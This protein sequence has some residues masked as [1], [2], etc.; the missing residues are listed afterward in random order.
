M[1]D[2]VLSSSKLRNIGVDFKLTKDDIFDLLAEEAQ[3]LLDKASKDAR[4]RQEE[5]RAACEVVRAALKAEQN[6]VAKKLCQ[7][8]FTAL[9]RMFKGFVEMETL[10]PHSMR[11]VVREKEH[12][13]ERA[14]IACQEGT[15]H[16]VAT[17]D[18][19]QGMFDYNAYFIRKDGVQRFYRVLLEGTLKRENIRDDVM[20]SPHVQHATDLLSDALGA[21]NAAEKA[22]NEA[23]R[24]SC[25]F[26]TSKKKLR[27]S[28]LRKLLSADP[29]SADVLSNI[30][31]LAHKFVLAVQA[32]DSTDSE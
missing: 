26:H 19:A 22:A 31:G 17:Y 12:Y 15:G 21:Y 29:Q 18:Y 8:Q 14:V 9:A 27:V 5:A 30:Q 10:D 13:M 24:A 28:L 1:T 3:S 4:S 25:N 6:L 7:K 11:F 2:L 23:Y 32:A 20:R 16:G